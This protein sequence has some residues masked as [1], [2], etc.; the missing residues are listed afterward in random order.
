MSPPKPESQERGTQIHS[1][2]P[3]VED[4]EHGAETSKDDTDSVVTAHDSED[5]SSSK[6]FPEIVESR[7]CSNTSSILRLR[8]AYSEYSSRGAL[9]N[10][11]SERQI[12]NAARGITENSRH[13]GIHGSGRIET[14]GRIEEES[15]R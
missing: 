13:S 14:S 6:L 9:P 8:H 1:L 4:H 12:L 5:Q 15:K 2:E 10:P 3:A 11:G 7:Q